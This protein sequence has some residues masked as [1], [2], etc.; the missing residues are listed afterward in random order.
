MKEKA[1]WA[2]PRGE[3]A[4][5]YWDRIGATTRYT[6]KLQLRLRAPHRLAKTGT[7]NAAATTAKLSTQTRRSWLHGPGRSGSQL[8]LGR[9]DSALA[10]A[11]LFASSGPGRWGSA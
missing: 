11:S 6:A 8:R 5:Y 1:S 2:G 7:R 10:L 4:I 3:W 9:W